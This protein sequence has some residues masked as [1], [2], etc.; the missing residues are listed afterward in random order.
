MYTFKPVQLH[1]AF[2]TAN[3]HHTQ[4]HALPAVSTAANAYANA[5]VAAAG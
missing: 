1:A 3:T 2:R 4:Q 5:R